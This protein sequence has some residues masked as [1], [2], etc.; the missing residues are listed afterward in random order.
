MNGGHVWRAALDRLRRELTRAQ[1]D[2]WLRGTQLT[3]AG[4]DGIATLRVRTTFARELLESRYRER[5]EAAITDVT[6]HPCR[7]RIAVGSEQ[8]PDDDDTASEQAPA[9][10]RG[11]E[12]RGE[13]PVSVDPASANRNGRASTRAGAPLYAGPML[14]DTSAGASDVIR[15][16]RG[17]RGPSLPTARQGLPAAGLRVTPST[18]RVREAAE[19]AAG[20]ASRVGGIRA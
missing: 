10:G 8:L 1:F 15:V 16:A 5:I 9:A 12:P 14:F 18:R 6:G 17:G 3:A 2:T 4:E 11:P 13:P 7:L 19:R 20:G